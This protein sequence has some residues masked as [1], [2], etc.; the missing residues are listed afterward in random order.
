MIECASRTIIGG[1]GFHGPPDDSGAVKLGYA[2]VPDKRRRGYAAEA[3]AAAVR[4]VHRQPAVKAAV[5][6]CAA[7]KEASIA[8]L[9]RARLGYAGE[10]N[11]ELRWCYEKEHGAAGG[12]HFP[13]IQDGS[14]PAT[15]AARCLIQALSLLKDEP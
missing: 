13:S 11:G 5:A 10:H 3:V 2:V 6:G 1:I 15:E 14:S 12:A 9:E 7:T 4:W 8:T